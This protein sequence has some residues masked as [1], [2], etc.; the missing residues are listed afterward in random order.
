MTDI[1]KKKSTFIDEQIAIVESKIR[2]S[3][4][5]TIEYARW[6]DVREKLIKA[7][8]EEEAGRK[9]DWNLVL[10]AIEIAANI[11]L[12]VVGFKLYRDI[13]ALSYGMDEGMALCNGRVSNMKE[14]VM[15]ITPKKV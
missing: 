2:S 11:G 6:L 3:T 1:F 13:A 15:K 7:K 5:G 4:F 9:V 10:R 14:L 8:K 12:A